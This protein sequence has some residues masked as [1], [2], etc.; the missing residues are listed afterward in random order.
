ARALGAFLK[1]TR[2]ARSLDASLRET[3]RRCV[4]GLRREEVAMAAN[5]SPTWYTWI[6]QGRATGCSRSTL[7]RIACALSMD[8]TERKHLFDLA[9]FNDDQVPELS[10][11]GP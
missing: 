6:E 2:G 4:K 7:D 3:G 9:V 11:N 1:R 5:I 8:R 10:T